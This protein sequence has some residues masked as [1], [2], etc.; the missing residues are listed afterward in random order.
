MIRRH[1]PCFDFVR[2]IRGEVER[3]ENTKEGMKEGNLL[4]N[5]TVENKGSDEKGLK[6]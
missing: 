2:E 4:S 1:K 3:G 6:V 5:L